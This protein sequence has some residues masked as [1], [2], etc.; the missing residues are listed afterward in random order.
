MVRR[1]TKEA[2]G[3]APGRRSP[4]E[5]MGTSGANARC[6]E[7]RA[8]AK[9]DRPLDPWQVEELEDKRA[10]ARTAMANG[11]IHDIEMHQ[12]HGHRGEAFERPEPSVDLQA[13]WEESKDCF[14]QPPDRRTEAEGR[15]VG[16]PESE[17]IMG[18]LVHSM[19][20]EA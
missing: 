7:Q 2:R 3:H 4:F 20:C 18:T 12:S 19:P 15:P 6:G 10:L 17:K 9:A 11:E 13:A 8:L 14:L 5:V 16:G 1:L